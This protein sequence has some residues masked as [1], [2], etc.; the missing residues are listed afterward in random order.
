[1]KNAINSYSLAELQTFVVLADELNFARTGQTLNLSSSSVSRQVANLEE[2]VGIKLF[3]RSTRKV[4]LTDAGDALYQEV[5]PILLELSGLGERLHELRK[6]IHGTLTI[7]APRW[8]ASHYL[9]P[10]LPEI[11]QVHPGLKFEVMSSDELLDPVLSGAD[12]LIRFNGITH[13]D[14][15]ARKLMK[16]EYWLAASP[17]CLNN[18]DAIHEPKDLP[19]DKLLAYRFTE[20]HNQWLIRR[21]KHVQRISIR[22]AAVVSDNPEVLLHTALNH[23][24]IALLPDIGLK[25]F[26]DAGRLTRLLANYDATPNRFDNGVYLVYTKDKVQLA[27]VR[28]VI[29][30]LMEKLS[31]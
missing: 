17:E 3:T 8:Y 28:A 31:F 15:V 14:I 2:A 7:A 9:A 11:N 12:L 1:M 30:F 24:G 6:G 23:G 26:V 5:R 21:G 13:P 19:L 29:D 10:I 22:Q 20:P 4:V 18:M 16:Y 25:E 27:R